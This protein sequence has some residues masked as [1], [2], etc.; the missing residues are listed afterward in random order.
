MSRPTASTF[1]AL[2]LAFGALTALVVAGFWVPYFSRLPGGFDLLTHAHAAT[3]LAW[4]G[5]LIVQA[6]LARRRDWSRHRRLGRLSYVLIPLAA[7]LALLLSQHRTMLAAG[8]DGRLPAEPAAFLFIALGMQ[9]LFLGAWI[10]AIAHRREPARHARYMIGT[11]LAIIDPALARLLYYA[12]PPPPFR[13]ELLAF[14][15]VDLLLLWLI[16][17]ERGQPR[18]R[19]VF[20]ILLGAYLLFQAGAFSVAET[21]AWHAFA[22]SFAAL[23]AH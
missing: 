14:A 10:L 7:M 13:G 4:C 18:G 1:S 12:L 20:P 23:R 9:A 19:E 3:M 8:P 15:F 21:A 22:E 5:L 11:A 2:P 6:S 17:R 16:W